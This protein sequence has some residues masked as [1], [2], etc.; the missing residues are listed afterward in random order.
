MNKFV[1]G[2]LALTSASSLAYAGGSETKEWSTLD[3]DILA[4][5]SNTQ[6][7]A[8][9]VTVSGFLRVRGAHSNDVD[10]DPNPL[11]DEKLSGFS[12][13]NARVVVDLAQGDFGAHIAL[14][15][16][17]QDT[18]F[19]DPS[20]EAILLDAYATARF[21]E[22][23]MAMI[24]RFRAPF[25][26]SALLEE[27]NMLLLDRTFN[28]EFWDDRSEGVQV[29]FLFDKVSFAAALQNGSDDLQNGYMWTGRVTFSPLGTVGTNQEGAYGASSDTA[30]KFGLAYADD[31]EIS[32]G[33]AWAVEAAL[34]QGGFSLQ[35]EV[36]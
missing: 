34:V 2:A 36:V 35:L 23:W 32:Q 21:G 9:A 16:V 11:N 6:G 8:S 4:L 10:L 17:E 18:L 26:G 7:G 15:G 5:T 27:N 19:P 24:G 14:E 28:G 20:L 25:L 12:I 30:L 3:R 31:S 29:N 22:G 1:I 33:D 13:D